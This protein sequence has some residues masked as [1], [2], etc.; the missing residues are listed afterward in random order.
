M[1][2]RR[3]KAKE[4]EQTRERNRLL[5][6]SSSRERLRERIRERDGEREWEFPRFCFYLFK[7]KITAKDDSTIN[8]KQKENSEKCRM[9][10][11]GSIS[12]TY[13][14]CG[15]IKSNAK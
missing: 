4:L 10:G 1:A 2:M 14:R 6:L 9:D 11:S 5:Y 8:I 13:R 15:T 12:K 3:R 7:I